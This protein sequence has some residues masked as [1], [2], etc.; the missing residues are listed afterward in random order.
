MD[1]K[2]AITFS[3]VLA[4]ASAMA[5]QIVFLRE[6]LVVFYGNEISIGIIFASWL[7]WG[8]FGSWFLGRFSDRIHAK[9]R[10]F[11]MC[12][13]G[14][15]IIFPATFLFIRSSRKL[16][17]IT[18][19][20]II[21]YSPMILLTF[22]ALSF[23]CAVMGF[24][25][26]LACRIYRDVTDDPAGS[27]ASVY[28]LE[29]LGAL[30]GG[31]LVS[32][33]MIRYM[34]PSAIIFLLSFL[35]MSASA[36]MQQHGEPFRAKRI[37]FRFTAALLVLGTI[38]VFAGGGRWFRQFSLERL[39]TGFNVLESRNS[40]YGNITVIERGEQRSFYE[41]G[42]HLYTVPDRLSAEESVHFAL[43]ENESP[44][45]V[46][47]IGGGVG[48]LLTEIL[49]HPVR[50]IDYVE[51]DP[52]M[53]D[54]AKEHLAAEDAA[55]LSRPGVN[56]INE[57]G[58]FFVKKR[59]G[60]YDC[61][62][63]NLGDPYTAQ[64]NRFYTVD[65]FRELD[66]ILEERAVVLFAVTSSENYI[67]GELRD[68]LRSIYLTAREVFPEV[69]IIPGDTA[70]FLISNTAG[71][72]TYDS[73]VLMERMRRR[74]VDARYVREYYLF[75]KLSNERV[76]YARKTIEE[77]VDVEINR[78]FRPVSYYYATVFWSTHFDT[79]FFRRLLRLVTPANIWLAAVLFCVL[80]L[81]FCVWSGKKRR[82]R[83]VLL[84]VMT[85]GFAEINFQIAVI[86]SFQV[87]YGYVFYKLGVIITSFM[88]GLAFGGWIM[89]RRMHRFKNDMAVFTWTQ[90]AVCFYPLILPLIFLW[91]SRTQSNTV[92]WF[93][94]NLIFPF[95]P[96]IAGT[97]GGIQFPL[98]NKICL[99]QGPPGER[100]ESQA[101][102]GEVGRIAGLSYGLD[103]LG[104]CAGSFLAAAFLVPVLGIFQTCFLVALINVTVL[105]ILLRPSGG[106]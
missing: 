28:V 37:F 91:I 86:L 43:L 89:A 5:S 45:T 99:E 12:Q 11:A 49:K 2:K 6:F 40:V 51:L 44:E 8:A 82:K 19:G 62:I 32:Y 69:F 16:M 23:S 68:Y 92:S 52:M 54:L 46:L 53:I 101:G 67:S 63:I 71:V 4:G 79:P 88:I 42:L 61:V 31:L 84:A 65:F 73:D 72:L 39:W 90:L 13:L 34:S 95:L 97:I 15:S 104:A 83:T 56:V 93:G 87:I 96:V 38:A 33:F 1:F 21:G 47:L 3:M 78:D 75:N 100:R 59:T 80:I 17:G 20:E 25:F 22:A 35:N 81:F 24:M 10:V 7:V 94:A 98:A 26:S 103:L 70:Y 106:N 58:R 74:G 36:V 18:T 64:L 66:R 77:N 50:K 48:G 85:T 29:A 105:A 60:L 9:L 76:E 55:S 30:S 102:R 57:D 41:N 14:L 27:V